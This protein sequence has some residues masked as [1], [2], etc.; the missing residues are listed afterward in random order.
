MSDIP[1]R[2]LAHKIAPEQQARADF[3]CFK[4][5]HNLIAREGRSGTH[6]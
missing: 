3:V 6:G 2:R 4:V 5:S 1:V